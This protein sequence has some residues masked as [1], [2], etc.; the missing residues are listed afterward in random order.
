MRWIDFG[1][2]S[3]SSSLV[4]SNQKLT[5]LP[6]SFEGDKKDNVVVFFQFFLS[7]SVSVSVSLSV[8]AEWLLGCGF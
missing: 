8:V 7:V 6:L 5:R 3:R 1:S 2:G 4:S